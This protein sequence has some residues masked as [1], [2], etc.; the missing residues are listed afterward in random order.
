MASA[1]CH[2]SRLHQEVSL[3][4]GGQD[5]GQRPDIGHQVDFWTIGCHRL[6][7]PRTLDRF[8][9]SGCSVSGLWSISFRN[10]QVPEWFINEGRIRGAA[11][12]AGRL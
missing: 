6:N 2:A 1:R 9:S 8:F 10:A 12:G 5:S 11:S 4:K 7:G 3:G